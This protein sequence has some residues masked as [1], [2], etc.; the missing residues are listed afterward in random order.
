MDVD[1]EAWCQVSL[2]LRD[3]QVGW[4]CICLVFWRGKTIDSAHAG[5]SF[6]GS[7]EG[8]FVRGNRFNHLEFRYQ[9]ENSFVQIHL[10]ILVEY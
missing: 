6:S 4:I 8:G 7:P 3:S 9:S 5:G 2:S 1:P 10:V